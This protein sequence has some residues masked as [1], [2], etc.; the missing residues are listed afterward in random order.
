MTLKGLTQAEL[1]RR[2]GVAQQTIG[3]LVSGDTYG[4][5]Y[6]HLIAREL[7]TTS[8]YLTG[9]TDDPD[10]DAPDE[11]LIDS[12]ERD[13]IELLRGLKPDD[14]KAVLTLTRS[15]ANSAGT[16]TVQANA[17]SFQRAPDATERLAAQSGR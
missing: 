12:T 6:L 3:R 5:R 9:E 2:V 14:R 8:A 4:S 10:S 11:P 16:S 15:L 1:A 7:Q 17:T 13:W